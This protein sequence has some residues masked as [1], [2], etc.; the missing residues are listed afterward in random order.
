MSISPACLR[1][2]TSSACASEARS[3]CDFLFACSE[4]ITHQC[5]KSLAENAFRRLD[6]HDIS[7]KVSGVFRSIIT[8]TG[9]ALRPRRS[10]MYVLVPWK[11]VV[12][13]WG[14]LSGMILVSFV[15]SSLL[16]GKDPFAPRNATKT[17]ATQTAQQANHSH[18]AAR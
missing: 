18:K 4:P 14:L 16:Q 3:G 1:V 15:A 5:S 11:P 17:A 9:A 8:V 2:R 10:A 13:V 6:E 7:R 12:L